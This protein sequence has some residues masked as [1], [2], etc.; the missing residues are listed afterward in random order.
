MGSMGAIT[1]MYFQGD[2]F[3]T[4]EMKSKHMASRVNSLESVLEAV[5]SVRTLRFGLSAGSLGS[6][7][8]TE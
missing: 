2:A 1:P 6:D 7:S 3:G 4:H 8:I 5:R